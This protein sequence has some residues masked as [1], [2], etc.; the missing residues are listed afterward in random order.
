MILLRFLALLVF[1]AFMVGVLFFVSAQG[2]YECVSGGGA[3]IDGV[4]ER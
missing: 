4:C 1:V 3:I 2:E